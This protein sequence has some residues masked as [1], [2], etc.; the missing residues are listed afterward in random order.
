ME[1]TLNLSKNIFNDKFFPYLTDYTHR[2]EVYMG[3]AGSGK[4]YHITQKIII[5]CCSEP[6]R[7]MVCRRY[8][9]TIRQTVFE[10]F[11]EV[12][13]NWQLTEY[14]KINEGDY[15]ITFPNGSLIFFAGLDEETKLLSLTNVSTVWIEEAYEV[16]KDMVDQLNLRLRGTAKNQQI[17]L[18]FNPISTHSWLYDFVNNPPQN[19]FFHHSTFRDNKFLDE[20]NRETIEE[21]ETRNPQKWRIFGL[22]EWGIDTDG[23]VLT[24]WEERALDP[25]ELAKNYEHRVG[26]DLGFQDPTTVIS[27]F[28]DAKNRTIYVTDEFYKTGQQLDDVYK[29]I[30][31]MGLSKSVIWFD[32]AEPRTIDYMKHKGLKA[33]PSIKGK[34][35]VKAGLA[36]LQN[37]KIIVDPKCKNL[38]MEL[39]NFSY[40]KDKKTGKFVDDKYTHEFSHAIDGLRY[41]YSP[42]YT[43]THLRTM[44]K[45]ILGL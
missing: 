18:S 31:D 6:I 4:S 28:Y 34:D 30:V 3:S 22:G 24:N 1:I 16:P 17:I 42:L 38:I 43:G 5:R 39:S 10:L 11:K 41:A 21:L 7:V 37:N 27:S 20:A 23:L 15:R 8:G 26:S 19:F 33:K 35:S 13:N 9:T 36:F 14:I 44:D 25:M 2:W 40:E 45:S 32:S 29:A 12:I